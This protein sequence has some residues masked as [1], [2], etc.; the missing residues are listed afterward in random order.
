M[1]SKRRDPDNPGRMAQGLTKDTQRF[2]CYKAGTAQTCS[3]LDQGSNMDRASATREWQQQ[4]DRHGRSSPRGRGPARDTLRRIFRVG[5][6]T[7]A[8]LADDAA[9]TEIDEL[10][11][12]IAEGQE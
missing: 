6:K 9:I 10:Q 5:T 1:T 11:P 8:L 3:P 2:P 12:L 4:R 7:E